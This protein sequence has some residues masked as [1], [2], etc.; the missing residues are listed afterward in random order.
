MAEQ[1]PN[2][3]PQTAEQE[4]FIPPSLLLYLALAGFVAAGIVF[5]TQDTFNVVGIGG[6]FVGIASLVL[7][8]LLA[9][10]QARGVLTGRTL[11]FGGF[12]IFVTAVVIVMMAVV[13]IFARGASA[14]LDLTQSDSFSL[15]EQSLQAITGIAADPTL[16]SIEILAFYAGAQAGIRDQASVLFDSYATASSNKISYEFI[17]PDRNPT[18]A[19]LYGVTRNGQIVVTALREDTDGDGALDPDTENAE[20][21]AAADQGLLTNAI[22]KVAADG[23]FNAYFLTVEDSVSN[24]MT[25]LKRV[26]EE[27][28]DWTI[29]DVSLLELTSPEG[30][31]RLNDPNLDGEVVI[32]PG[33]TRPLNDQELQILID[34]LN[35]G[36]T[37]VIMAE[38]NINTD[39]ESLATAENLNTYL[40]DNFGIRINSDLILDPAQSAGVA[41]VVIAS[42]F[43]TT[44]FIT[45]SGINRTDSAVIYEVPHSLTLAETPPPG[46]TV[47][48]LIRTSNSSYAKADIASLITATSAEEQSAFLQRQDTDAVGPFTLAASAENAQTGAK[49]VV[50]G[51]VA[52]A[53]DNYATS[54]LDN[55]T[56]AVNALAWATDFNNF[57]NQIVVQQNERPQDQPVVVST[58]EVRTINLVTL[59]LLPFGVLALGIIVWWTGRE[60]ARAR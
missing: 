3:T 4:P 9:P 56:V 18:L 28:Y 40:F 11:R 34:Y 21:I 47:T 45:T 2:P 58:S 52:A 59:V 30:D 5:F 13:Y 53:A 50:F 38:S 24:Q 44:S 37:V 33:G 39:Q 31:F 1:T 29:E 25:T 42:T 54:Q 8:G 41:S 16:P 26:F 22:L 10:D 7:W 55:L 19:D 46:V 20:I 51:S 12:S 6:L 17:D 23:Q 32:I 43:D 57:F 60:R 36:G 15:T 27:R 49:L 48:S 35:A 14:R